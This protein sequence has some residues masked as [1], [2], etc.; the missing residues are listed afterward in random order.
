MFATVSTVVLALALCPQSRAQ[1]E[2]RRAA[3]GQIQNPTAGQVRT[4][5]AF[6]TQTIRGVIAAITAEGEVM[7]DYRTNTVARTE[8]AFLTVVG[9][10]VTSEAAEADR[11]SR[12]PAS[13]SADT[14]HKKRH[15]V[16]IA[17][18]TPRTKIWEANTGSGQSDRNPDQNPG[19]TRNQSQ[20]EVALDQLEV[21][22]HVEIQ[23][24]PREESAANQAV[25]QT[26]QMRRTHGRHRTFVGYANAITILPAKAHDQSGSA[27][28]RSGDRDRSK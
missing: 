13:T 3:G 12:A 11:P 17:W 4:H 22:D 1:Q 9:S 26:D 19:Q 7:L 8:A 2:N 24:S 20:Q 5:S 21:G 28:E 23:F 14:S 27:S 15:N 18:L 10:P 6:G 16:Y 25:H